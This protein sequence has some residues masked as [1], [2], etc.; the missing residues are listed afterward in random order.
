MSTTRTSLMPALLVAIAW[1][2]PLLADE[3][4]PD[5][6]RSGQGQWLAD[7]NRSGLLSVGSLKISDGATEYGWLLTPLQANGDEWQPKPTHLVQAAREYVRFPSRADALRLDDGSWMIIADFHGGGTRI[8]QYAH[9]SGDI[10]KPQEGASSRS[11]STPTMIVEVR[12]KPSSDAPVMRLQDLCCPRLLAH[13]GSTWVIAS[14]LYADKPFAGLTWIAKA[15]PDGRA[16]NG[17][18]IGDGVDPRIVRH[19]SGFVCAVRALRENQTL[20]DAAPVVLYRS[21]DLRAWT[22]MAATGLTASFHDYD[23]VSSGGTLWI[24]GVSGDT[25]PKNVLFSYDATTG[26]W[27]L[28]GRSSGTAARQAGVH[29]LPAAGAG[30]A[31]PNLVC[32]EGSTLKKTELRRE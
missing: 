22:P 25:E 23:M 19:G 24:A 27:K 26:A 28:Q 3:V 8:L 21:D 10:F 9:V 20:L 18:A 31:R 16:L 4:L 13:D 6:V 12:V 5:S 17:L 11:A 32:H 15:E 1:S 30:E 2:M 29:L 14:A 7:Q